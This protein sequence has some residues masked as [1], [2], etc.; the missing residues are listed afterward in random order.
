MLARSGAPADLADA[1]EPLLES[2]AL[3][4][5]IGAAGRARYMEEYTT[6][7]LR[8]RFFARFEEVL[9]RKGTAAAPAAAAKAP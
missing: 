8:R 3:R 6:A 2:A 9:A 5:E 1:L 4:A 7:A